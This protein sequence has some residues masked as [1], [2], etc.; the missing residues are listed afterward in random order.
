MKVV[1]P[2]P[3]LAIP[4]H[5]MLWGIPVNLVMEVGILCLPRHELPHSCRRYSSSGR[6]WMRRTFWGLKKCGPPKM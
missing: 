4:P 5:S 3:P 6:V 2:K 1:T